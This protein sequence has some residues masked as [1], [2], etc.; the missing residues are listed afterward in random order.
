MM[1]IVGSTEDE[2]KRKWQD[3]EEFRSP[4]AQTAYFSSLS[5]LD[6]GVYDPQ[7]PLEDLVDHIPG[8]RGA[9]TRSSM[10]GPPDPTP[11]CTT[12]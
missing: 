3:L 11:R 4:E 5:G 2:A 8:I 9:S 10:P 7:T 6:L 1:V 12:F